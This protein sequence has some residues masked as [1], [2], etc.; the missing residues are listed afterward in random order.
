MTARVGIA[1]NAA[2]RARFITEGSVARLARAA[3]VR[4]LEFSGPD[5]GSGRRRPTRPPGPG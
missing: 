4:W 5:R 3:E 2:T 1:C